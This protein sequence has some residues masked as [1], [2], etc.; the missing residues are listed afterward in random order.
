MSF[1]LKNCECRIMLILTSY[2]FLSG[3]FEIFSQVTVQGKPGQHFNPPEQP[4]L[5]NLNV[6]TLCVGQLTLYNP[7]NWHVDL[8]ACNASSMH[9]TRSMLLGQMNQ[10]CRVLPFSDQCLNQLH[11]LKIYRRTS[12]RRKQR[13]GHKIQRKIKPV[14][15]KQRS[16]IHQ[17]SCYHSRH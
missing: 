12:T 1:P 13:G 7:L 5:I 9:Y 3:T 11:D 14:T 16:S 2:I 17:R 15:A 6:W 8:P 4:C 10:L